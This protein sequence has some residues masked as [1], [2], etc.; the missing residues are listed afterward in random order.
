[1]AV[2]LDEYGG[3]AWI[4]TLEDIVE[5][6]FWEIRDETDKETDEIRK[7]KKDTLVVESSVLAEEVLKNFDLELENIWLNEKEFEWETLSYIITEKLE[8]FPKTWEIIE[9]E[10]KNENDENSKKQKLILKC[11]NVNSSWTWEIEVKK[12]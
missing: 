6:V 10:I 3:V 12:V 4:V 9:Y 2:I 1:L 8:R 7:I 5:E 11:L